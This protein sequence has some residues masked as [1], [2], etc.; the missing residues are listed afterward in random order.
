MNQIQYFD[1]VP[2]VVESNEKKID[3]SDFFSKNP[4]EETGSLKKELVS[5]NRAIDA[6]STEISKSKEK[7]F[8]KTGASSIEVSFGINISAGVNLWCLSFGG[9]SSVQVKLSWNK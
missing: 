1:G 9:E 4:M 2:F 6:V 7:L 3:S 5:M 8:E